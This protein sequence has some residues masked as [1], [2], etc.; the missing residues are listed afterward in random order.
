MELPIIL[1]YPSVPRR[2]RF[3]PG[4]V[5]CSESA[6]RS[7]SICR[8]FPPDR[9]N[10]PIFAR[11]RQIGNGQSRICLC[12]TPANNLRRRTNEKWPYNVVDSN[13]NI[14][15]AGFATRA[16][17]LRAKCSVVLQVRCTRGTYTA[18][19]W[20]AR[21][22]SFANWSVKT[23]PLLYENN[24]QTGYSSANNTL[25]LIT[26]MLHGG[27]G[28]QRKLFCSSAQTRHRFTAIVIPGDNFE[29]GILNKRTKYRRV[30]KPK[31]LSPLYSPPLPRK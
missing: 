24:W 4:T 12:Q 14:W 31:K 22:R 13:Y 10:N 25:R 27:D 17:Y 20:Y 23:F 1:L 21:E 19:K 7:L 3:F 9:F 18:R 6:G 16:L 11:S 15:L 26:C 28:F 2:K 30:L 5:E 8:R 29:I